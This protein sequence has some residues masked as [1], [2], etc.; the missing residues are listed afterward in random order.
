MQSVGGEVKVTVTSMG[1]NSTATGKG[2]G[3]ESVVIFSPTH[4]EESCFLVG[5]RFSCWYPPTRRCW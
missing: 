4:D 1:G 5:I 2:A 3:T